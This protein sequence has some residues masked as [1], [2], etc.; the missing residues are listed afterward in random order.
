MMYWKRWS[1]KHLLRLFAPG[2]TRCPPSCC[3]RSGR[4]RRRAPA[5]GWCSGG[6]RRGP[7]RWCSARCG[8]GCPSP[9]AR[10]PATRPRGAP[11]CPSPCTPAT[12]TRWRWRPS[13]WTTT[14]SW[15]CRLEGGGHDKRDG[16]R[17]GAWL[18]ASESTL[19]SKSAAC[20]DLHTFTRRRRSQLRTATA[21]SSGGVRCFAQGH[22]KLKWWRSQGSNQQPS[23]YK[24]TRSTSWATADLRVIWLS[25]DRGAV[26]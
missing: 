5:S 8:G 7:R 10:R 11:A 23:G 24:S 6:W 17:V 15:A 16:R 2:R 18:G 21:S 26:G 9:R 25:A 14:G 13:R 4:R 22:L 20:T 12:Q 19:L 3:R 1:D